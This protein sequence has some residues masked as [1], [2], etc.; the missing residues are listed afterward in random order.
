MVIEQVRRTADAPSTLIDPPVTLPSMDSI[1]N[2]SFVKAVI[3]AYVTLSRYNV[4]SFI[5]LISNKG[6][7]FIRY[8]PPFLRKF[9]LMPYI[10]QYNIYYILH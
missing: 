6:L 9:V 10:L 1:G 2:S 8:L 3:L 4:N 7:I 5:K